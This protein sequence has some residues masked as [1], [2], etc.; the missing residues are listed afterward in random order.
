M[1]DE[2]KTDSSFISSLIPHHSSL[3]LSLFGELSRLG[4]L[5][6]PFLL[7]LCEQLFDARAALL[8]RVADEVNLGRVT[9]VEGEA[10]LA[11]HVGRGLRS[12]SSAATFSSSLPSTRT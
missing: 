8:D 1:S 7:D 10:E 9:Q 6:V 12:A 11:A 2:V 3:I 5:A 4:R